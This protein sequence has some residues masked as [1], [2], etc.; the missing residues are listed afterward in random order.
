MYQTTWD[1]P[2]SP[3]H[4]GPHGAGFYRSTIHD[5]ALARL[6]YLVNNFY[7]LGLLVGPSGS[8]KTA[9]TNFF[10]HEVQSRGCEVAN[11]SV[12]GM[13]RDE[14]VWR[15]ATELGEIPTHHDSLVTLWRRIQDR[16]TV[17]HYQQLPTIIF[18]DDV[19][20]AEQSTLR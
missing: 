16:L 6:E 3:F 19:H 14:F 18:V 15:L 10:A 1:I 12:L 4:V 17:N 2:K 5:E 11:L 9:L 20:E 7:R 8:G 13:D